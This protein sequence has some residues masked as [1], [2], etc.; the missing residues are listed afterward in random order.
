[1]KEE[2]ETGKCLRRIV[3]P[4]LESTVWKFFFVIARNNIDVEYLK[5]RGLEEKNKRENTHNGSKLS[6]NEATDLGSGPL[7]FISLTSPAEASWFK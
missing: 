5:E 7:A 4:V 1:M 6:N 2:K 3:Q